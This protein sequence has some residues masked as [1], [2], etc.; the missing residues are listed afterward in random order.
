EAR[1]N[2]IAASLAEA[3]ADLARALG[4]GP[5]EHIDIAA[6]GAPPDIA[7]DV[8]ALAAIARTQRADLVA[9]ERGY[10][11]QE[12]TLD[13]AVLGQFPRLSLS[14]EGSHDPAAYTSAGA[15]A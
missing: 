15:G 14:V 12:A 8:D 7:G 6:P 1:A 3:H 2:E 4:V 9:L 10:E 13:A 5:A 11:S